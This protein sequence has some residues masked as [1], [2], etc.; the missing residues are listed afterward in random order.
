MTNIASYPLF[1]SLTSG[2]HPIKVSVKAVFTYNLFRRH[3]GSLNRAILFPCC[4][5]QPHRIIVHTKFHS[6]STDIITPISEIMI[7]FIVIFGNVSV[8]INRLCLFNPTIS[9]NHVI[10]V[11]LEVII[12]P[13]NILFI[14]IFGKRFVMSI[15]I[16]ISHPVHRTGTLSSKLAIASRYRQETCQ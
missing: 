3:R 11:F 8:R 14:T 5:G 6:F 2:I 16:F 15:T 4:T 7:P 13:V 9:T 12:N 10:T 1:G